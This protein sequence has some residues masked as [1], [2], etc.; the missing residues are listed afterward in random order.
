MNLVGFIGREVEV[1]VFFDWLC[2]VV[3]VNFQFMV[4]YGFE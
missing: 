3:D 4:L 1:K 2:V